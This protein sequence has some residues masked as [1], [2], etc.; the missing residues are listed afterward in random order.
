MA[1]EKKIMLLELLERDNTMSDKDVALYLGINE[2]ELASLKDE[3]KEEGV[4]KG[5]Q[6]VIDW[7]KMSENVADALIEVK[8]V[9]QK[10]I[11]FEQIAREIGAI[12]DVKSVFL[13]SGG[14][15]FLVSLER[16]NIKE[17][18]QFVYERLATIPGVTSTATH[19]ILKKYK[20]H[21]IVYDGESKDKRIERDI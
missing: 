12:E 10:G 6:D 18:S 5:S 2:K 20:D 16:K 19:F 8:V 9:P 15:D 21:G 11:G 13:M 17:I 7:S 3:L 4:I 1:N 14:Y